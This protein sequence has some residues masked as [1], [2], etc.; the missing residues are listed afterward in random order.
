MR[1]KHKRSEGGKLP[2]AYKEGK[3][4][5]DK[6]A[7]DVYSGGSSNVVKEARKAK[8]GGAMCRKDG[9][10]VG[11][12]MSEK[13]MDRKPRAS[14]GKVGAESRPF[15]AASSIKDRPGGDMDKGAIA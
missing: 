4:V 13:R 10:K 15:S 1:G 7:S 2:E 12:K 9:G 3:D 8:K 6:G 11:G 5:S 14:G